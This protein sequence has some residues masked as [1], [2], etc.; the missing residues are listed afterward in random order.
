MKNAGS[1][2]DYAYDAVRYS[3]YPYGADP[4]GPA[5]DGGDPVR[6]ASAGPFHGARPGD[7][8]RRRR[9]PDRDGRG[10]AR[11][12]RARGRPGR[13]ADRGRSARDRR[14]RADQRRVAPRRRARAETVLGEFD[15]IVAH[16]VYSWI[17]ADARD[18]LLATIRE[19]LA[20]DGIAY[21]SYNAEPGGY[22]RR[23]LRD[24][25]LWHARGIEP[26]D[27]VARA[28]KAQELYKFLQ[29]HRV[30]Q[31]RH[32]RRAARTRGPAARRRARSTGSCTT[33]SA[34]TGS[35]CW[36]AEFA[37]HAAQHGLGLRRRG[38]PLRAAHRDA[39]VRGSSP[40]CGSWPAATGPRSRTTPTC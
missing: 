3:N 36:F 16:G 31:R 8:L 20:P 10:D 30:T 6:A 21:V 5:G 24:A 40:S 29:K 12:P 32:L 38:R 37:A 39:A 35:P 4:S 2:P 25:G 11:H 15:Y 13:G 14:D 23:M 27:E 17:P 33:T 9:Q 26:G 1:M 7:R 19:H 34:R 22:F 18:A 28:Q